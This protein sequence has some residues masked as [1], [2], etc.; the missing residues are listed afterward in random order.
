MQALGT[1]RWE[2]ALDF[3]SFHLAMLRKR[4]GRRHTA[5]SRRWHLTSVCRCHI[6]RGKAYLMASEPSI[7]DILALC[8]SRKCL[9]LVKP[10]L[11]H[12]DLHKTSLTDAMNDFTESLDISGILQSQEMLV[13]AH[14][15]CGEASFR[16]NDFSR[17]LKHLQEA[18]TLNPYHIPSLISRSKLFVVLGRTEEALRDVSVVPEE[19]EDVNFILLKTYLTWTL[20]FHEDSMRCLLKA[21]NMAPL[22]PSLLSLKDEMVNLGRKR[23]IVC[24][25]HSEDKRRRPMPTNINNSSTL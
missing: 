24:S 1:Q 25:S 12:T 18:L 2:K 14:W 13:E 16:K 17:A 22:D 6:V 10:D 5:S 15:G 8:R 20:G 3:L 21:M 7:Q 23:R 19:H 4:Q 9:S 11:I